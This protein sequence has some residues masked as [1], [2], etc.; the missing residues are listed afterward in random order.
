MLYLIL[1]EMSCG[2]S[3]PKIAQ[4]AA[5]AITLWGTLNLNQSNTES[6]EEQ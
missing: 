5:Y 2:A 3:M 4:Y 1:A 6:P